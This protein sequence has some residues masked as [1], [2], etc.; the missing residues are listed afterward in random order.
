M[1]DR[2]GLT[3]DERQEIDAFYDRLGPGSTHY[4]LLGV[5]RNADPESIRHAYNSRTRRFHPRS[6]SGQIP[7]TYQHRLEAILAALDEAHGILEDP[8]RRYLYD[9]ELANRATASAQRTPPVGPS[10]R[11]PMPSTHTFA[12]PKRTPAPSMS[13]PT[14]R[15][16]PFRRSNTPATPFKA[17]SATQSDPH[18]SLD[19]HTRVTRPNPLFTDVLTPA[20]PAPTASPDGG[21]PRDRT[22][23]KQTG[24]QQITPPLKQTDQQQI[25]APLKQ[26]AQPSAPP[27]LAAH[28]REGRPATPPQAPSAPVEAPPPAAA[29]TAASDARTQALEAQVATLQGEVSTLLAEVERLAVSVQL[30]IAYGLEPDGVKPE[31]LMTAGHALVSTRVAVA[32]MLARREEAAGRWEAASTL[33]QRASKA[34]PGEVMLLVRA[35]DALRRSG[36]DFDAAEAL[37]RQAIELDPDC[38]EAHA[39]LA[40]IDTRRK[41]LL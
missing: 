18:G 6:F 9:Q 17:V 10:K 20:R 33:W 3:L 40:V 16:D 11:T 26:T 4:D 35:A 30:T 32:T 23:L 13:D 39:A 15:P 5:A 12:S 8:V 2:A 29:P 36:A 25:T 37:A 28:S 41:S 7:A 22:S 14:A 19:V 27:T 34:R 31:Q 1:S 38:A 21:P 24:Q